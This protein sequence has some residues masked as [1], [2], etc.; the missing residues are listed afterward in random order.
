MDIWHRVG[1]IVRIQNLGTLVFFCLNLGMIIGIFCPQGVSTETIVPIVVIYL[2][3]ILISL[4]PIGEWVLAAFAGAHE[5]KRKDIKIR[6][7][8]LLEIVYNKAKKYEA[9]GVL[10]V[11]P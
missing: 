9:I 11:S 7:I 5:I 8:P 10:G 4:S 6:L 3:S 1:R 2:V